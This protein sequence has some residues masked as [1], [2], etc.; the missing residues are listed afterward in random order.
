MIELNFVDGAD[1]GLGIGVGGE[2]NALGVGESRDGARQKLDAV[3]LRHAVIDQEQGQGL[4]ALLQLIEEGQCGLAGVGRQHPI[5]GSVLA[6]QVALDGL[7]NFGVVV[8]GQKDRFCHG[9]TK[10]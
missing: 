2:E 8:D 4:A 9:H 10:R 5:V 6:A 3:H 7:Q 1:G